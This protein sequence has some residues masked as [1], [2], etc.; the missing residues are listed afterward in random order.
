[1][2][3]SWM[4]LMVMKAV[5]MLS[6]LGQCI[7]LFSGVSWFS[8]PPHVCFRLLPFSCHSAG[9]QFFRSF[10]FERESEGQIERE[11][12]QKASVS[13]VR[14]AAF[15]ASLAHSMLDNEE[16]ELESGGIFRATASHRT[17]TLVVDNH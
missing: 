6:F 2:A 9:Q 11:R 5:W 8:S 4:D 13:S 14:S 10:S 12:G 1:M 7:R 16:D 17:F 3:A 15:P